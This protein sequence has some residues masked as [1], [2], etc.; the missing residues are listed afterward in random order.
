[1]LNIKSFKVFN[2]LLALALG[3]DFVAAGNKGENYFKIK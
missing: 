1:M 2:L 3:L